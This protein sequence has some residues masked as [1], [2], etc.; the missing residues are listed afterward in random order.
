MKLLLDQNLSPRLV[1]AL[2]A[3]YPG[4]AHVRDFGLQSAPDQE[5]WEFAKGRGFAIT[6]KD[7]DFHQMSFLLGPP[8]K[9]VW[10]R[11][12]NCASDQVLAVLL[13][14]GERLRQFRADEDAALL[15]LS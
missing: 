13:R 7:S 3:A 1:L 11:L 2:Q 12:G 14:E 15:V 6:S 8:P 9:V 5:I 4:S 10:L